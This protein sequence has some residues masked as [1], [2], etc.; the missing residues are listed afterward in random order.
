MTRAKKL[1]LHII[2]RLTLYGLVVVPIILGE[3]S[4]L[5]PLFCFGTIDIVLMCGLTR[6]NVKKGEIDGDK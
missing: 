6:D 1:L 2:P 3:T 5:F 4:F